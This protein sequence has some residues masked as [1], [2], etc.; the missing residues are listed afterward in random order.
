MLAG[1]TDHLNSPSTTPGEPCAESFLACLGCENAR[2]LP[3]QLPL[4]IAALDQL[5]IL[6]AHTDPASWKVLHSVHHERLADLVN[7]YHQSEQAQARQNLTDRQAQMIN[8][9]IG[10][11]M[12][13]R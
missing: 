5:T 7:H 10:G 6:R 1:C 3:H 13:L 4:Q 2:A 11:R 12:E 9:L 8:D